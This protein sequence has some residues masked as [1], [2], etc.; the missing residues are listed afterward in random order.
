MEIEITLRFVVDGQERR[1]VKG[2]LNRELLQQFG[3]TRPHQ[4]LDHRTPAEA[5]FNRQSPC[6]KRPPLR[7]I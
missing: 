7:T 4:S 1:K 2:Q 5:R 6:G 3:L